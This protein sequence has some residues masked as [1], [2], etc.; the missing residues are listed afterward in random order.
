MFSLGL[1]SAV[2]SFTTSAVAQFPKLKSHSGAKKRWKALSNGTFKRVSGYHILLT[3]VEQ[4]HLS[5]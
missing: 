3:S 4:M 2:R 1:R 5:S